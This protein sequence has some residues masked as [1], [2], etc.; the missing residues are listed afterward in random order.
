MSLPEVLGNLRKRPGMYICPV[1]YDTAVAFVDGY[2]TA[3]QRGLLVGFHEW[4]VVKVGEGNNL[5]WSALVSDLMQRTTPLKELK[6]P[7]DHKAAIEFLFATLDQFLGERDEWGGM[8]RIYVAYERWLH[9][10]DWY[11]PSSPDW[12][13]DD[14]R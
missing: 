11:G 13:P 10:Q 1:T 14:S 7:D 8:R 9:R 4:L 12:I 6:N 5:T 3:T 2:D